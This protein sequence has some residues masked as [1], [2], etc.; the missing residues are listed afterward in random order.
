MTRRR[1]CPIPDERGAGT[2][3]GVML[4][5]VV[6]LV[7]AG[8]L[9]LISWLG[10]ARAAQSAADL[11]ALAGAGAMLEGDD[12]C[13]EAERVAAR[14]DVEMLSCEEFGQAPVVVV[15]VKV[16]A[17]VAAQMRLLPG[18]QDRIERTATAGTVEPDTE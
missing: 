3:L 17:Q 4:C 6:I 5:V 13:S 11:S 7:A 2:I 18:I 8:A 10:T 14:N 1:N 9:T 15:E 16:A 12:G